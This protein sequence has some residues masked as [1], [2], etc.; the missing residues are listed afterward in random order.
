MLRAIISS[1]PSVS[2]TFLSDVEKHGIRYIS[3]LLTDVEEA[4]WQD[5]LTASLQVYEV[6]P[7]ECLMIAGER[8]RIRTASKLGIK[9]IGVAEPERPDAD[10][11]FGCCEYVLE[12]PEEIDVSY[13]QR[14]FSR[15]EGIPLLITETEHLIIR[16]LVITDVPRL[17]AICNQD[18]V[19]AFIRDIG[20]DLQEEEEKHKAYI[21]NAYRFFDYGYWGV[22]YK[23]TGELIGRCGIQDNA[24]DGRTE[25]ELGYLLAEEYRGRGYA[26]EAAEAVL[27]YAFRKLGLSRVVAVID[28]QNTAS[29]HVA[30]KCGMVW[31]KDIDQRSVY[32]ISP[33]CSG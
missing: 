13:V 16:E 14:V 6:L 17:C 3:L 27:D 11:L 21:E 29:L 15:M 24:V 1:L 12:N 30:Q 28:K 23:P 22:Y 19:R 25:V 18:S 7:E 2:E 10:N 32:A 31:E 5:R 8:R 33:L 4:V 26:K 20:S 9:C